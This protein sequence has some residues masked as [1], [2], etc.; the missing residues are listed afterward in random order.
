MIEHKERFSQFIDYAS[1]VYGSA[2]PSDIDGMM[3]INGKAFILYEA[4]YK[5]KW[6]PKA[7]GIAY[8]RIADAIANSGKEAI[9][10]VGWHDVEDAEAD[11]DFGNCLVREFYYNGRWQ[12]PKAEIKVKE[13]T[14]QFLD[15]VLGAKPRPISILPFLY[16]VYRV[17]LMLAQK[18]QMR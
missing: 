16:Q 15:Y 17:N 2:R 1:I 13:M 18:K 3:E 9:V 14:R 4:K 11:V 5:T 8:R 6:M 7:Q 10:I 12:Q